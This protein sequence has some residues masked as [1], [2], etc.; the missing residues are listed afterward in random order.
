M[1]E[2]DWHLK[3]LM[4]DEKPSFDKYASR[5]STFSMYGSNTIAVSPERSADNY[6]RITT[7]SHQPWKVQLLGM[8]LILIVK[9]VG[10]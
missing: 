3:E 4:K 8:R 7:N 5:T 1:F 2:F 10:I 6:T 9:K